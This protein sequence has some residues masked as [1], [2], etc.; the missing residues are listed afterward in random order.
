MGK[1]R[2]ASP[3]P[4]EREAKDIFFAR[5]SRGFLFGGVRAFRRRA[6][7]RGSARRLKVREGSSAG[8]ARRGTGSRLWP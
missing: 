8:A 5:L 2:Q 4:F 6:R 7:V 1:R 3:A